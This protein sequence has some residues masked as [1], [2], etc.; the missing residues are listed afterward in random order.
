MIDCLV[1]GIGDSGDEKWLFPF[2]GGLNT[3]EPMA[4]RLQT[5]SAWAPSAALALCPH[6]P[7]KS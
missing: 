4:D 6:L 7:V 5:G 2:A 1:V 3:L